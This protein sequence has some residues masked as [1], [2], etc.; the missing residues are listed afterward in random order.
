MKLLKCKYCG[1]KFRNQTVIVEHI[2]AAHK[3]QVGK[4]FWEKFGNKS[5][6]KNNKKS[7]EKFKC[8]FCSKTYAN[9]DGYNNHVANFHRYK[10]PNCLI[11][12][13]NLEKYNDHS[14]IRTRSLMCREMRQRIRTRPI[15]PSADY[16]AV[17]GAINR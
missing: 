14:C 10:C 4:K 8:E 3:D 15:P 13:G 12:C 16:V 9:L 2:I 1:K 5:D 6:G 11:D 7:D 17:D